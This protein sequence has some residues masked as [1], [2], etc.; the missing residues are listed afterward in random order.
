MLFLD[1]RGFSD[2]AGPICRWRF[3]AANRVAFS[4]QYGIGVP[5]SAIFEA[6]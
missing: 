3:G 1:V 2:Y 4:H 6:R 5:G